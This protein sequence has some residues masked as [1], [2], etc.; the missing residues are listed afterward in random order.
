MFL[1]K[2]SILDKTICQ[3]NNILNNFGKP[4]YPKT[5]ISVL[6]ETN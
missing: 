1:H 2:Y 5:H 4:N 6:Y 3:F